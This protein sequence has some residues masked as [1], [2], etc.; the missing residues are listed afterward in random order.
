MSTID[1]I[2]AKFGGEE[3]LAALIGRNVSIVRYWKKIGTIPAKWHAIL[4]ELA[5]EQGIQLAPADFLALPPAAVQADLLAS[6]IPAAVPLRA[7]VRNQWLFIAGGVIAGAAICLLA[8]AGTYYAVTAG[9]QAPAAATNAVQMTTPESQNQPSGVPA[10]STVA[11]QGQWFLYANYGSWKTQCRNGVTAQT[12]KSLCVGMLEVNDAKRHERVFLWAIGR[13]KA[14][15]FVT[16]LEMPT[17]LMI[18]PGVGIQFDKGAT[19]RLT[20]SS[21]GPKTCAAA[22]VMDDSFLPAARAATLASITISPLGRSP[23]TFKI[24][25]RG[26]GQVL[27]D[28]Q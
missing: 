3:A 24:P 27:N 4:L 16:N 2:I 23:L 8:V 12:K 15:A 10:S 18:A 17:G 1:G 14:G 19:L 25:V 9:R 11:S 22:A 20:F 28:L 21:C 7:A 6:A 5:Q 26:L 13:N